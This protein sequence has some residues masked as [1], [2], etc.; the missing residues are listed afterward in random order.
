[1]VPSL[2]MRV[3]RVVRG[4]EV[5]VKVKSSRGR[6]AS[7][8]MHDCHIQRHIQI[9]SSPLPSTD[10][11]TSSGARLRVVNAERQQGHK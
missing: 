1:M 6:P 8:N 9:V 4:M 5:K 2:W 3:L 11:V 7:S 10:N